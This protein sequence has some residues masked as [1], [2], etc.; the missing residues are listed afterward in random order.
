MTPMRASAMN[1][2]A[3]TTGASKKRTARPPCQAAASA[4]GHR[5]CSQPLRPTLSEGRSQTG[6]L[7]TRRLGA[8]RWCIG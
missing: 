7:E 3:S 6:S 5:G 8:A 2:S 1:E 4:A